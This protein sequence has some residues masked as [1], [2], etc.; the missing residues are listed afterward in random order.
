VYLTS[1][2]DHWATVSVA[3][4]NSRQVVSRVC[5]GIDFDRDAFP[6]MS[7][8]EG[9]AAGV[10]ARAMRI[11]FTGELSYEINVPANHA[12]HVWE[13]V[14]AAG[15]PFGITPYGTETMHVLRAEK[16][17]IIVGQETDG[18]VN[19]E[20]LGMSWILG[21]KEFI[22]KRGLQRADNRRPDR[23]QLV[24][25]LTVDPQTVLP[26]GGQIVEQCN[27]DTT[28]VPMLGHVTSSYWSATLKRSIALA[29][30]K[31]GRE[32]H[33]STV[34]VPLADGRVIPAE[35]TQPL[36]YDPEGAR[37]HV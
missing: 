7:F 10:P 35:I 19:P 15:E 24:G 18:A 33:G 8:R 32:R 28:P 3:G 29:L 36:F 2:T 27:T 4:P 37:Q 25:L 14:M 6:F 30:V 26:E 12:R 9:R 13:A 22:G 34:Y 17:F 11:S 23:K 21:K 5:E 20:D 16:G 31:S 1:V